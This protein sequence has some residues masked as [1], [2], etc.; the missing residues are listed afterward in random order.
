M[1]IDISG[2][3]LIFVY[4]LLEK[5]ARSVDYFVEFSGKEETKLRLVGERT[6]N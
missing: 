3:S 6:R 1:A 2:F 5:W 4:I